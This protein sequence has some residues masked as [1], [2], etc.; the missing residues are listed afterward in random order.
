MDETSIIL[1]ITLQLY[2]EQFC[3]MI[4]ELNFIFDDH[5]IDVSRK[6]TQGFVSTQNSF[7]ANTSIEDG[8]AGQ[9]GGHDK[10]C[11]VCLAPS[12]LRSPIP[13]SSTCDHTALLRKK[14]LQIGKMEKEIRELTRQRDIVESRVEGLLQMI[15]NDQSSSQ[16]SEFVMI[17]NPRCPKA[18]IQ[19]NILAEAVGAILMKNIISFHSTLKAILHVMDWTCTRR[20]LNLPVGL[21]MEHEICK[22]ANTLR[23]Y[24]Q[25]GD[26]LMDF[27]I[28]LYGSKAVKTFCSRMHFSLGACCSATEGLVGRVLE[29]DLQVGDGGSAGTCYTYSCS[30]CA[31]VG[32]SLEG[33]IDATM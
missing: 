22:S 33:N 12:E 10:G 30:E 31:L 19:L 28:A 8:S 14:D 9:G 3:N 29:A 23:S 15:G 25:I 20:W 6:Q 32:V 1:S 4:F 16:W 26:K 7:D 17:L 18:S 11:T 27:I 13:T 2:R 21:S 24:H 5:R